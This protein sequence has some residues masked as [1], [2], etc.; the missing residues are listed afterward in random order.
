MV[1]AVHS[2]VGMNRELIAIF[3]FEVALSA[4]KMCQYDFNIFIDQV[5]H[6]ETFSPYGRS[7]WCEQTCHQNHS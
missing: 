5:W 7:E 4:N 1:A 2:L 3:R 6:T